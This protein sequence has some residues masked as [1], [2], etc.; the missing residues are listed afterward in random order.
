[1]SVSGLWYRQVLFYVVCLFAFSLMQLENI[2]HFLNLCY[3]FWLTH[4][5]IDS[6]WPH[7]S[8]V[9]GWQK[10]TSVPCYHHVYRLITLVM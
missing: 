2:H 6:L 10:V 3:N 7:L 5:G 8:S 4:F 9:G 1:M